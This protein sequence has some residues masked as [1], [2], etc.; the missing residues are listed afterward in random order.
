MISQGVSPKVVAERLG[1]SNVS[2]T[3]GLY[4][5]VMPAHD[6]AAVEAFAGALAKAPAVSVTKL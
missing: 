1:H 5:H 6:R 3:L 4:S 2:I